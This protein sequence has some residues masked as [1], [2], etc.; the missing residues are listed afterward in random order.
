[1]NCDSKHEDNVAA[2]EKRNSILERYH[3]EQASVD[4]CALRWGLKVCV[5]KGI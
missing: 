5:G 3:V 1:M 2:E 4:E